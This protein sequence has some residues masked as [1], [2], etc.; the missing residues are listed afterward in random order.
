MP[1]TTRG[2]TRRPA[3]GP[4]VGAHRRAVI[5]GNR[6]KYGQ[7]ARNASL[8]I[9][10]EAPLTSGGLPASARRRPVGPP[11]RRRHRLGIA[12]ILGFGAHA[13]DLGQRRSRTRFDGRAARRR[14]EAAEGGVGVEHRGIH[15]I[16]AGAVEPADQFRVGVGAGAKCQNCENKGDSHGRAFL[17][18]RTAGHRRRPINSLTILHGATI[19]INI[20][21]AR[22]HGP[23]PVPAALDEGRR[24]S[25]A[26]IGLQ[27]YQIV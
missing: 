12:A 18:Q 21:V 22:R 14:L 13:G 1:V 11:E 27:P 23:G 9:A 3:P 25:T 2:A 5:E 20:S 24:T 10:G 26:P 16:H 7:R 15:R 4:T 17:D 19:D 6:Q 8:A